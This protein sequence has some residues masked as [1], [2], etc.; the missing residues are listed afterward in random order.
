MVENSGGK[1]DWNAPASVNT[2]MDTC[3]VARGIPVRFARPNVPWLSYVRIISWAVVGRHRTSQLQ[4]IDN[5]RRAKEFKLMP[6]KLGP[7][8]RQ[9]WHLHFF[10]RVFQVRHKEPNGYRGTLLVIWSKDKVLGEPYYWN[11]LKQFKFTV[12][13][14]QL[15][16]HST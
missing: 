15:H 9:A 12:V 4:E 10:L 2:L 16:D 8:K 6:S 13:R 11:W 14:P 3:T 1:F 7:L 5:I